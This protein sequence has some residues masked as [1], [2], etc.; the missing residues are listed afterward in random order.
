MAEKKQ[1]QKMLNRSL[2]KKLK[3]KYWRKS[4]G[5]HADHSLTMKLILTEISFGGK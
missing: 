5:L 3:N 4:S 2:E 1:Q